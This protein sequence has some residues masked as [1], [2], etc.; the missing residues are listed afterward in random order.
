VAH[1]LLAGVPPGQE[2]EVPVS[3][4]PPSITN[5]TLPVGVVVPVFGL[6]AAVK[7][8]ETPYIDGFVE[9]IM[10]V[11]VIVVATLNTTV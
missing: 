1:R 3:G 5:C 9:E 2:T 4:E 8:T 7:V 10:V 6:T 11:V